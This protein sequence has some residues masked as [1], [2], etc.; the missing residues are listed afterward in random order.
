MDAE[1]IVRNY[2]AAFNK[3]GGRRKML[4]WLAEDVVH[5]LSQGAR[6]VGREVFSAFMI[7][8]D[9]CYEEQLEDL[10]VMVDKTGTR[11]AAEFTVH[12]RYLA[13]DTGVP[14]GTSPARGQAYVISAGAFLT[15]RNEKIHRVATHYNLGEWVRAV[16]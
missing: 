6:E 4:A 9:Y 8:M 5:D 1:E 2:Y 12:G 11:V 14:P 3:P 13:T 10:V 15:V 7:H 16:A